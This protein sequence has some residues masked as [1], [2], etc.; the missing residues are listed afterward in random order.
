[1][2]VTAVKA[3]KDSDRVV[4]SEGRESLSGVFIEALRVLIEAARLAVEAVGVLRESVSACKGRD[5]AC[6]LSRPG[7]QTA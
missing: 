3:L 2:L 1:M 5:G 4:A 6:P 7:R